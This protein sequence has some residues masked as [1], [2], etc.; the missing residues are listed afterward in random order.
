MTRTKQMIN[1]AKIKNQL[2]SLLLRVDRE[3]DNLKKQETGGMEELR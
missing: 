3:R 2:L 1:E